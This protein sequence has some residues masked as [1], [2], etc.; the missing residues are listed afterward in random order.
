M[1][2]ES[3]KLV[4]N[5]SDQ[6]ARM[7][8]PRQ[9]GF[10]ARLFESNWRPASEEVLFGAANGFVALQF[11]G[12]VSGLDATHLGS[13]IKGVRQ[14]LAQAGM[15]AVMEII[16]GV[17]EQGFTRSGQTPH[18]VITANLPAIAG[19]SCRCVHFH[20]VPWDG[21]PATA[22]PQME[23]RLISSLDVCAGIG[24]EW[25]FRLGL[26]HN[27]REIGLFASPQACAT[28][29]EFV[30]ALSFVWDI[31]HTHPDDLA[32]F[33]AL[34]PRVSMLHISDTRLP[35]TNEHLPLGLGTVDFDRFT[36]LLDA[37]NFDGPAILEIGGHP[38]SGGFGRDT[39]AALIESRQ[40]WLAAQRRDHHV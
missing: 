29:L 17:N 35:A 18:E 30:P 4:S 38:K 32:G 28:V 25:G 13:E 14:A 11:P 5:M 16:L 10:N 15:M 1:T 40:Q 39:N 33:G 3:S 24:K 36:Q 37:A 22:L 23:R 9:I 2:P 31:N 26:E 20:F 7:P 27:E 21:T 12:K 19:L 8:Q 34:L 6:K